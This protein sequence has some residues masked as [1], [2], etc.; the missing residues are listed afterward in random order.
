[1]AA[2]KPL[3][4]VSVLVLEDDYYLADDARHALEQ[5]G[6]AVL[7]PCPAPDEAVALARSARAQC[8]VVDI[9]LGSGP[10]FE[11]AREL[12][13]LGVPIVLVTGYDQEV[14]PEDLRDVPWMPKPITG[15]A[16]VAAVDRACRR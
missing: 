10:S 6:A 3:A 11:P 4:G 1:M 13:G 16:L 8:A 15:P 9:N 12:L 2:T 7:G 5:A 14:I